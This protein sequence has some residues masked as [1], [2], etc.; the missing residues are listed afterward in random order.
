MISKRVHEVSRIYTFDSEGSDLLLT[1]S[2]KSWGVNGGH[3]EIEFVAR[4]VTESTTEGLRMRLYEVWAVSFI[5]LAVLPH[6]LAAD[7]MH[8]PLT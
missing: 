1:G 3:A 6:F 5:S 4:I 7:Y 8:I 2:M